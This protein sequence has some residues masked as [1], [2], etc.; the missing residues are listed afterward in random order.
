[1]KLNTDAPFTPTYIQASL[2]QSAD[3]QGIYTNR[4]KNRHIVLENPDRASN[5]QKERDAKKARRESEKKK[6]KTAALGR[7]PTGAK[8]LWKLENGA[9]K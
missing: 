1:V 9:E 3:P 2:S 7:R 5:V 4:V 6:R 8:G